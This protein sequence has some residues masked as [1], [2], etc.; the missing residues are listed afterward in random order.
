MSIPVL[1]ELQE[2]TRRFAIAGSDLARGDMKLQKAIP[3]LKKMGEK[4]PV[5]KR[6][7]QLTEELA[8]GSGSSA[9]DLLE[10]SQLLSSVLYTMGTT[11]KQG[12]IAYENY[13]LPYQTDM[14]YLSLASIL[15]ALESTGPGRTEVVKEAHFAGKMNDL[16][17]VLPLI[18]ALD[19]ANALLADFIE[20]KVIPGFGRKIVPLI[21]ESFNPKGKA[22]DSRRIRAIH[23]ILGKDG[24]PFYLEALETGSPG[25]KETVLGILADYAECEHVLIDYTKA[26]KQD[27]RRAAF[28]SLA[29]RATSEALDCIANALETK[30]SELII[31]VAGAHPSAAMADTMLSYA[32]KLYHEQKDAKKK[33]DDHSLL[34][35]IWTLEGA[36]SGEICAFLQEV[37]A[38][39]RV[40][41]D[42]VRKAADILMRQPKKEY[43]EFV[44][45]LFLLPKKAK[46][47]G[48][49]LKA[50]LRHRSAAEIYDMYSGYVEKSGK[51]SARLA[52]LEAME[53]LVFLK[54]SLRV[55]DEEFMWHPYREN[56]EEADLSSTVE[57]DDRWVP[58]LI[59]QDEHKLVFRM[60]HKVH[61]QAH[62]DFIFEKINKKPTFND[63]TTVLALASLFQIGYQDVFEVVYEVLKKTDAS[64]KSGSYYYYKA[65]ENLALL[66]QL[67]AEKADRL[68]EIAKTEINNEKI[69]EILF[70]ISGEMSSRREI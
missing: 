18:S 10:L 7:S 33:P 9:D 64:M 47:A 27:I 35:A 36:N 30:D 14:A 50:S 63:K 51:D 53:E 25:V 22:G 2:E 69:K 5:F 6:L 42:A 58:L 21:K 43:V 15:Q 44:E 45:K 4:V 13:S 1:L 29:K 62:L 68:E 17:L 49:S 57:W 24:L 66:Y 46:L 34:W 39:S 54:N 65:N 31:E 16:R 48:L 52:I 60:A 19:D 3:V 38:D 23:T 37:A 55:F 12:E 32:K 56:Y 20:E 26:K 59:S 28:T 41:I 61:G 70:E 8:Y 11:G 40:S 67:P